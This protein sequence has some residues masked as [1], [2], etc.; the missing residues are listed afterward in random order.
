M[1]TR[2]YLAAWAD[3]RN[4]VD[5]IDG[6]TW[7]AYATSI[8]NASLVVDVYEPAI[9]SQDLEAEY[10]KIEGRGMSAITRLREETELQPGDGEAIIAFLD[11]HLHRGRYADRAGERSRSP[12]R[13][14][15]TRRGWRE[16]ISPIS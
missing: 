6:G 8:T 5:V 2:S 10:A 14:R 15:T 1:V 3:D 13:A 12:S 4:T 9:M 7:N 11:M 16:P